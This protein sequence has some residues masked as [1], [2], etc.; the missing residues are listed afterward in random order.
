MANDQSKQ[1]IVDVVARISSLEKEMK[2]AEG[3]TGK[4][5]GRMRQDSRSAT[6]AMES[7]MARSTNRINQAL[8]STSTKIGAFGKTM[9][10]SLGGAL[11]AGGVAGIVTQ[12]GQIASAVA[13]VG[14]EAKRAGVGVKA[15][16]ELKYVAE[17]NRIGV[18]SLTDGLKEL[19][20]RADEFIVTGAGSAAEAFRRLGYDAAT[21]KRKLADPSALFTEIIGKLGQL[22]KAAQICVADEIFGGNGGEKFVQL[23]SQGEQGIRDTIAQAHDP[24]LVMSKDLIV[25]AAELDRKFQAVANTIGTKLKI[26]ILEA[27]DGVTAFLDRFKPTNE[28]TDVM[29]LQAKLVG[30]YNERIRLGDTI[31]KMEDDLNSASAWNPWKSSIQKTLDDRRADFAKLTTEAETL[32]DRI[33]E[34]QGRGGSSTK[35]SAPPRLPII[36]LVDPKAAEQ[37]KAALED[38]LAQLDLANQMAR[39][40]ASGLGARNEQLRVEAQLRRSMKRDLTPDEK[41]L[42]DEKLAEQSQ[43]K[44]DAEQEAEQVRRQAALQVQYDQIEALDLENRMLGANATERAV[45]NAV[46]AEE[47]KLRQ[48]NIPLYSEE[49]RQRLLNAAWI[50]EETQARYDA[51]E[52]TDYWRGINRGF[53][54]ELGS[55][56]VEGQSLWKSFGDAAVDALS[57]IAQRANDMI[58]DGIFDALFSKGSSGGG[59]LSGVFS[60]IG[61]MLGFASGGYTGHGAK[62]QVAGVVHAGEYVINAEATKRNFAMLEA[63]NSNKPGYQEGGYVAP[64][65]SSAQMQSASA[66]PQA[67][68]DRPPMTVFIDARGADMAAVARLENG[69]RQLNASIEQRSV[70]AVVKAK[71]G[72]GSAGKALK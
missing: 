10:A 36:P 23:I 44:R 42:V 24:G 51:A 43:L 2:R 18:D 52:A 61:D 58:A 40:E 59:L 7:D 14:D 25:K 3:V 1:L 65:P 38:Y 41:K 37:S 29:G 70:A 46:F 33:T 11:V 72:L 9:L 55:G 57:R 67:N 47:I 48:E 31:K 56:I 20:L 34:L 62:D 64:A 26:A 68:D 6:R 15:F 21:L 39:N 60:G 50:A 69:F 63:I 32:L 13:A 49:G 35:T 8:A 27:A 28:R 30:V 12:V 54:Q 16:Q 71:T 53:F 19:N 45:A 5:F 22:D 4:S 66:S 17:Q